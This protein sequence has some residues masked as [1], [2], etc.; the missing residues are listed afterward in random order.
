MPESDY[1]KAEAC[2]V[3][4]QPDQPGGGNRLRTGKSGAGSQGQ[5]AIHGAGEQAFEPGYLQ[6]VGSGDAPG[7]VRVNRP[8]QTGRQDGQAAGARLRVKERAAQ[9]QQSTAGGDGQHPRQ[10]AATEIL[11]E[12]QP[13]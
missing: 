9:R 8:G 13:G 4:G 5:A 10:Q 3:A 1:V 12:Y 7:E 11:L 2:P 6:G